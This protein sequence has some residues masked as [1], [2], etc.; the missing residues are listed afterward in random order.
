MQASVRRRA[1]PTPFVCSRA[2]EAEEEVDEEEGEPG[3]H[4]DLWLCFTLQNWLL[5]VGRPV[6]TLLLPPDWFPLNRPGV[7]EYLNVLYN[8][9]APLLLLRMLGR[10]PRTP[11]PPPTA[12]HLG[13]IAV[14][15]GSS[16]HLV[17]DSFTRRLLL[18]DYRLHLSVRENPL[19]K[20][21]KDSPLVG[22]VDAV[23]LLRYYD[24]TVSHVM[25]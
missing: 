5:D 1:P 20:Q 17:A 24:D 8:F 9:T 23:E 19:M 15:M 13:L 11:S 12:L 2:E 14:V 22:T 18:L 3:F 10:N 25:W 7:Q 6:A 16:L 4:L 21:F